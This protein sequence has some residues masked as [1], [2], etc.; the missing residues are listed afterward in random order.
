MTH[1]HRLEEH[2]FSVFLFFILMVI[3][4]GVERKLISQRLDIYIDAFNLICHTPH[5]RDEYSWTI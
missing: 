2:C 1:R 3:L 5:I 4:Y